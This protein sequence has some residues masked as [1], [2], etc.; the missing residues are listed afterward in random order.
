MAAPF[1]KILCGLE[2][3]PGSMEAARQAIALAS[4]GAE[5]KLLAVYA[6]FELGPDHTKE[7][8]REA[9]DGATALAQDAGVEV[10]TEIQDGRYAADVLS[11]EAKSHDVLV[12]G[13]HGKSRTAEIMLGSTAKKV[14]HEIEHPLLVSRH[15]SGSA[16]PQRILFA[17]DGS[18]KSRA[19]ASLAASVAASFDSEVTVLHVEDSHHHSP[20]AA[21]AIEA[22]VAQIEEATGTEP[23]FSNRSGHAAEE[24]VDAAREGGASLIVIGRRGLTGLKALG[25]VSDRVAHDAGCSVLLVPSTGAN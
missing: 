13:T 4:A 19:T 23:A 12:I 3:N 9:L 1:K 2:G 16:F 24:I 21:G 17:S 18:D 11:Q 20:E 25:S 14:A 5:L 7:K 22:E 10:S 6:S 8:L 15:P